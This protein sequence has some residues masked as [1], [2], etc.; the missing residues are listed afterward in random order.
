MRKACLTLR[1]LIGLIMLWLAGNVFVS[2]QQQIAR[3]AD[4]DKLEKEVIAIREQYN[5]HIVSDYKNFSAMYSVDAAKIGDLTT[6][7]A[8]L[9]SGMSTIT[10]ILWGIV[11]AVSLQLLHLLLGGVRLDIR[12]KRNEAEGGEP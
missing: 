11:A 1:I 7:L 10:R 6:R 5:A 2:A 3:Q 9:E 12:R 8:V 4:V